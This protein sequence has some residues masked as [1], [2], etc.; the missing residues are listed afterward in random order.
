M[1]KSLRLRLAALDGSAAQAYARR[2]ALDRPKAR[3]LCGIAAGVDASELLIHSKGAESVPRQ[4]AMF[5][6]N[7]LAEYVALGYAGWTRRK[8]PRR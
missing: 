5:A 3:C 8:R 7:P 6:Q 2:D 4:D 1:R